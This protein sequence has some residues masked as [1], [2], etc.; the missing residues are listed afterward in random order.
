MYAEGQGVARDEVEAVKW[1]RKA[2]EH[3]H[4]EA[5]FYLG[6]MYYSGRGVAQD[7]REALYWFRRAADQRHPLGFFGL[8]RCYE[9]GRGVPQDYSEAVKYYRLAAE[10]GNARARSRLGFL[11]MLGRG[12]PPDDLLAYALLDLAVSGA[13]SE[14]TTTAEARDRVA[15][16]LSR[17]QL[18]AARALS[19]EMGKPG[20]FARA[21]DAYLNGRGMLQ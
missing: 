18:I 21:L 16:S 12:V 1:Y 8:G 11:Y 9:E 5:Q 3:G 14:D 10:E 4:A 20:N 15:A 6:M 17:E 2:A 19:R 13:A 7:G